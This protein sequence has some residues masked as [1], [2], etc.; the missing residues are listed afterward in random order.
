M[1]ISKESAPHLR[2]K[3]T[4]TRMMVD[5]LIA[6]APTLIFSFVVFPIRTLIF[7]LSS[8]AIMIGAAFVF[9][10]LKNMM[11]KDGLKHSFKERA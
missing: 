6:L 10:G 11:P 8:L 9:V 4:V 7:Y 3:A 5:V 2:R 1:I